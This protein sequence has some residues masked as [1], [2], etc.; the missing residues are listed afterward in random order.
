MYVSVFFCVCEFCVTSSVRHV[1]IAIGLFARAALPK[2][3]LLVP[4][5]DAM[6]GHSRI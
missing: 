2:A 5:G 6:D 4:G 3:L 1:H